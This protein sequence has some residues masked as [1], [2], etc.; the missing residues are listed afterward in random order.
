MLGMLLL[1]L[2][3][4]KCFGSAPAPEPFGSDTP[5]TTTNNLPPPPTKQQSAAVSAPKKPL[6]YSKPLYTTEHTVVCPQSLLFSKDD[7]YETL[8]DAFLSIWHMKEAQKELGCHEWHSGIRVYGEKLN[9]GT[10]ALSSG[11]VGIRTSPD[12]MGTLFT[13]QF[14]LTNNPTGE[15]DP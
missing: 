4:P 10:D 5:V 9:L 15:P 7:I 1:L 11:F 8:D 14:D 6:D 12:E 13:E 2:A 3:L